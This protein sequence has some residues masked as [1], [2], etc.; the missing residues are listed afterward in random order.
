MNVVKYDS[1]NLIDS[2]FWVRDP[3]IGADFI[4]PGPD[5][6]WHIGSAVDLQRLVVE[7][8]ARNHRRR[9]EQAQTASQA[10]PDPSRKTGC[11][12]VFKN[13][14]IC[15]YNSFPAGVAITPGRLERPAK[16][17][18]MEHAERN[19]IYIAARKGWPLLGAAIYVAW[20]P[21]ADCARAIV[22]SGIARMFAHEPDWS[23][24]CYGFRDAEAILKEGGV[25][26]C[27]LER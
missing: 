23:E 3:L 11:V 5:G 19:A 18:Y 25:E 8:N 13:G 15:G 24:E 17:T 21:C 1:T 12:I 10:S 22:Q 14:E 2:V 9:M 16:Y 7:A 27:F 4:V 6:V 20:Y 26:T